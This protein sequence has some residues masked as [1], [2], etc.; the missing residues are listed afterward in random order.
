[1]KEAVAAALRNAGIEAAIAE[2]SPPSENGGVKQYNGADWWYWLKDRY[3]GSAAYFCTVI[4]T[5]HSLGNL[6]SSVGGCAPSSVPHRSGTQS[7]LYFQFPLP[8]C[9]VACAKERMAEFWKNFEEEK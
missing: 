1:V 3:S 2:I 5:G 6:A 4:G 8:H 9:G 7:Y